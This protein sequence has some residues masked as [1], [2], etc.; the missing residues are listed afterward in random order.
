[1]HPAPTATF[2]A[3]LSC[4]LWQGHLTPRSQTCYRCYLPVLAGFTGDSL[5]RALTFIASS[6]SPDQKRRG[7]GREFDPTGA[8]CGLQ[9]TASSPSSTIPKFNAINQSLKARPPRTRKPSQR[10]VSSRKL[11]LRNN[12]R[13][14][15]KQAWSKIIFSRWIWLPSSCCHSLKLLS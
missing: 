8:G 3:S 13:R 12:S 2:P 11:K 14:R 7:L 10:P 6:S 5:W 9:G 1:V 4:R 15:P